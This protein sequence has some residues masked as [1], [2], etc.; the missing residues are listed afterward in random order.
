MSCTYDIV[1]QFRTY[2]IVYDMFKCH[3]TMS[4]VPD[5]VTMSYV[6]RDI[7]H[8]TETY[9]TY[10]IRVVRDIQCCTMTYDDVVRLY[11]VY[12]TYNIASTI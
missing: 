1:G 11:P 8:R 5:T 7:R 3:P 10:D 4:Y 6:D 9:S 12:N 2:N